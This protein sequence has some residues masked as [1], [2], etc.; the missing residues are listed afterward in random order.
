M[1]KIC[2]VIAF[3]IL[4]S[5][6]TSAMAQDKEK[7]DGD[8]KEKTVKLKVGDKAPLWEL[9]GSDGK[10]YKLADFKGKKGVVVAWYPAAL[11]GG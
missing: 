1:A 3:G 9:T 8:E 2:I 7:Q 5:T 6:S 10:K 4:L 11:T